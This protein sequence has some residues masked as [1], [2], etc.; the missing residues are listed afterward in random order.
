MGGHYTHVVTV[1]PKRQDFHI[2]TNPPAQILANVDQIIIRQHLSM[3]EALTNIDMVNRYYIWDGKTG[4]QLFTAAEGDIGYCSRGCYQGNREFD[5]PFLDGM[6]QE[7]FRL[8]KNRSVALMGC[9]PCIA[10]M[11]CCKACQVACCSYD[12]DYSNLSVN[13]LGTR[14]YYI[15]QIKNCSG[16]PHFAVRNTQ[17]NETEFS[18]TLPS[19]CSGAYNCTDVVYDVHDKHGTLVATITKWWGGGKSGMAA[20]CLEGTNASTY[21]IDIPNSAYNVNTTFSQATSQSGRLDTKQKS[22]LIGATLLIDYSFYQVK[23]D[24]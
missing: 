13:R 16:T 12:N 21:V 20:C 8:N 14:D 7:A 4:Q 22:A 15:H 23:Q 3:T 18:V 10:C 11:I 17:T 2:P 9:G 1:Q 6:N 24:K 5:M 19:C